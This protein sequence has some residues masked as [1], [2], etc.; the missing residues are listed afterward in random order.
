[1][2]TEV[3][4]QLGLPKNEAKIYE[5]LVNLGKANISAISSAGK[6]NRRNVYDSLANLLEKGLVIRVQEYRQTFFQA[7]E[8]KRLLD[9]LTDQKKKISTLVPDL[10]KVYAAHFPEEQ[11]FIS[12]GIEGTKNFWKYVTSQARPVLF[13]GGKG[14][15]HDPRINEERKIYFSTCRKRGIPIRGLFDQEMLDHG[16]DVYSQYDPALI[17][18]FPKEYSTLSSCDICG[19]RVLFFPVPSE[20]N[21]ENI[22]IFNIISQP[23]ADSYRK[24]FEL[25]WMAAV[26]LDKKHG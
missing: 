14:A 3:L 2:F 18:F 17:R 26:P 13:I 15:W 19:N 10:K 24:W 20:K 16:Q 7:A 4:Q 25:I 1:M 11:A 9:L 6:V 8:P 23:L 21:I 22:I 5:A 12:R